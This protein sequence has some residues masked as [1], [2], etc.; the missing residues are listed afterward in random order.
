MDIT[1]KKL[2]ELVALLDAGR[3]PVIKI[4]A[5]GESGT[6]E[7]IDYQAGMMCRCLSYADESFEDET[8]VIIETDF[9]EFEDYNSALD[10]PVW[11]G[12]DINHRVRWKDSKFYPASKKVKIFLGNDTDDW[13][14]IVESSP[15]I[16]EFMKSGKDSYVNFLEEALLKSRKELQDWLYL[17]RF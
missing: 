13:Y 5:E 16:E 11:F 15:L 1:S 8:V 10:K 4:T 6:S 9:S 14:E 7:C 17:N 3:Q 2:K 12:R